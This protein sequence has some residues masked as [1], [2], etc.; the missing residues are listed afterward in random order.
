MLDASII[1]V[2]LIVF[3]GQASPGPATLSI[4]AT[5]MGQSRGHGVALAFG[6]ITGSLIWSGSAAMGL[7]ALMMH[8]EWALVLLKYV[9]GAYLLWLGYRSW[10]SSRGVASVDLALNP[11]QVSSYQR[12]YW[13]GFA[14]H[15]TNPKA[16][17]MFASL[18][19]F[20]LPAGATSQTVWV[21]FVLVAIQ[22]ALVNLGYAF[23]FSTPSMRKGYLKLKRPLDRLVAVFFGAAGSKMLL[24]SSVQ[25]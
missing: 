21:I 1:T 10:M 19:S 4:A 7:A 14:I 12:S 3:V 17:M 25:N 8:F 13:K 6:I 23:L 15:I 16:I 11:V 24:S 2:L 18:Y 9:G 5:S 20:G 22:S